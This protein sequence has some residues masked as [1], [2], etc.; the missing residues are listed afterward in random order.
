[1]TCRDP[2]KGVKA[3]IASGTVENSPEVIAAFLHQHN[4]SLDKEQ[5]GEYLGHHNDLEVSKLAN[6]LEQEHLI[7]KSMSYVP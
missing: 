2:V 6:R 1:M 4:A 7:R 3:L 5:L